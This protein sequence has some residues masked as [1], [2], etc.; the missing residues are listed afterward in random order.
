M[1]ARTPQ[2]LTGEADVKQHRAFSPFSEQ[3]KEMIYSMGNMEYFEICE[4]TPKNTVPQLYDKLDERYCFL[5][6]RNMLATFRQ[7]S[8]T[9]LRPL[10]CSVDSQLR[11]QEKSI[12]WGTSREHTER[13]ITYHAAHLS[14]QKANKKQYKSILNRFLNSPRYRQSQFDIGWNEEHCARL[15]EIAAKDHSYRYGGRAHQTR[16]HLDP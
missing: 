13:E 10:R 11:H 1:D 4:I 12:S 7:S 8:K 3:S 14:S 9:K 2:A 15:D 6:M 5:H 16:K